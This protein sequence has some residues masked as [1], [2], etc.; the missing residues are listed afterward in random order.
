[1]QMINT[2]TIKRNEEADAYETA[3]IKKASD[4]YIAMIESGTNWNSFATFDYYIMKEVGLSEAVIDSVNKGDKDAVPYEYREILC[5]KQKEYI[6]NDYV[7][8]NTYYRMLHG[9]PP[10]DATEKDFVYLRYIINSMQ[11]QGSFSY[12]L[13]TSKR[14]KLWD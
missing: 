6:I 14:I 8:K 7:E 12:T 4:Q 2:I 13:N 10:I 9:E 5:R 11:V 1:M 3:E